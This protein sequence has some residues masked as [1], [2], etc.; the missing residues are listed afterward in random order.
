MSRTIQH[1]QPEAE[2]RFREIEVNELAAIADY[3]YEKARFLATTRAELQT[4]NVV[5]A[6]QHYQQQLAEYNNRCQQLLNDKKA[7][8]EQ[9]YQEECGAAKRRLQKRVEELALLQEEE[10]RE[11]TGSWK[12]ARRR[13]QVAIEKTIAGL[14]S[15]S[16]LLAKSHRFQEAITMRDRARALEKSPTHPEIEIVD[17]DYKAQF[18]RTLTRHEHAFSE[19]TSQ[20]EAFVKLLQEKRAVADRTAEA[21]SGIGAAY[22]SVEVMGVVLG[23]R[24]NRDVALPI[25]KHFSPRTLK[26]DS[27]SRLQDT[28]KTFQGEEEPRDGS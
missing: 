2:A 23:D 25:V 20:H 22:G 19:L 18:E 9:H 13:E 3:D 5:D 10:L 11:L 17:K 6:T 24:K 27:V 12:E 7:A 21:E 14:L 26:I 16:Q 28:T 4:S 1:Y 8:N 15:S